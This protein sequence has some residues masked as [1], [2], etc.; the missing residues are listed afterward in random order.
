MYFSLPSRPSSLGSPSS[1]KNYKY[2]NEKYDEEPRGGYFWFLFWCG[3][4]GAF[5]SQ[6]NMYRLCIY[7]FPLSSFNPFLTQR[8]N[9]LKQTTLEGPTR[10]TT[11]TIMRNKQ[12]IREQFTYVRNLCRPWMMSQFGL[13][14]FHCWVKDLEVHLHLRGVF[15]Y[16][17]WP[18]LL[19]Q[20]P[21]KNI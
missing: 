9:L 20:T 16:P 7:Y 13:K 3:R 15:F 10:I 2:I 17:P 5:Q 11:P 14:C 21:V 19:L 12:K 1:A 4:R 6:L 18:S 8:Q